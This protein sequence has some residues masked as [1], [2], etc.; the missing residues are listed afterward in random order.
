MAGRLLLRPLLLIATHSPLLIVGKDIAIRTLKKL[1]RGGGLILWDCEG[2]WG[3][4]PA[5]LIAETIRLYENT[6]KA[7]KRHTHVSWFDVQIGFNDALYVP[8]EIARTFRSKSE[9]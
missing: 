6:Q 7:R 5:E 9:G 3:L 2:E 4:V 8:T 1:Q